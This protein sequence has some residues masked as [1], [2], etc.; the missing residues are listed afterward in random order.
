MKP[1]GLLVALMLCVGWPAHAADAAFLKSLAGNWVG[2]GTVKVDADSGQTKINCKF[3]SQA[4]GSSI[5][6]DGRCTGYVVFSRVISA[7]VRSNGKSYT[8]TYTGSSTGPAGLSGKR[9]GNALILGIHWAK[10]VNG[11]RLAQLRLEKVGNN[12]MRLK[13]VDNDPATGKTITISDI[14]LRRS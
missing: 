5:S 2:G 12:G 11:D 1:T 9:S 6:L 7:D 4:V 3:V 14:N 10:S 13:T 8:G